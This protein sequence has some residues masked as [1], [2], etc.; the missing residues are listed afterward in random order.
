MQ[1]NDK[2]HPA[3]IAFLAVTAA[4][5]VGGAFFTITHV[6]DPYS[7]GAVAAALIIEALL[8]LISGAF[9]AL[10]LYFS[11]HKKARRSVRAAAAAGMLVLICVLFSARYSSPMPQLNENTS[12]RPNPLRDL[13]LAAEILGDASAP[14]TETGFF[15]RRSY[16]MY[17][18]MNAR[19]YGGVIP[20]RYAL[21]SAQGTVIPSSGEQSG[22][23]TVTYSPVTHLPQAITPYDPDCGE[24]VL[25][26]RRISEQI[27]D[28]DSRLPDVCYVQSN[29]LSH[30][31]P[32]MRLVITCGKE[33]V[34]AKDCTD[35]DTNISMGLPVMTPGD[36]CAQLYAVYHDPE[37]FNRECLCP[38]SNAA[39]Y[40]LE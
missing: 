14:K 31:F 36:Y 9:F 16:R 24:N 3:A 26:W 11:L 32:D 19:R 1:N 35:A 29:A 27:T 13:R 2:L 28:W 8:P 38:I 25:S 21:R 33:T 30:P 20:N 15:S 40:T 4:C 12:L 18:K 23:Y 34:A 5:T 6:P 39:Y 10:T 7:R 37:N 22:I 17:L